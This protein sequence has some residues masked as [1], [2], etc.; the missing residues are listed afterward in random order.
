MGKHI[1]VR[2]ND[3]LHC[4]DDFSLVKAFLLLQLRGFL[5]ADGTGFVLAKMSLHESLYYY[6]LRVYTKVASFVLETCCLF[7]DHM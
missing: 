4:V 5:V 2:R 7:F 1:C 6:L 3:G